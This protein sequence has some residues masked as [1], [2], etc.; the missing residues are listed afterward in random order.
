MNEFN[1]YIESKEFVPDCQDKWD[2][3]FSVLEISTRLWGV[4]NFGFFNNMLEE[5]ASAKCSYRYLGKDILISEYI[6]G[7]TNAE[8]MEK[9]KMWYKIN[10]T[11]AF[12]TVEE[13]GGN[14]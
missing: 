4:K 13:L 12:N 3:D 8:V 7:K 1:E 10:L 2:L 11:L 14:K 5:C 9:C 6:Y